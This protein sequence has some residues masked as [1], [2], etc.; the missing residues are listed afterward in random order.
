MNILIGLLIL[1]VLAIVLYFQ[2]KEVE[3]KHKSKKILDDLKTFSYFVSNCTINKKNKEIVAAKI[4]EF[5]K[6]TGYMASR[7]F[8]DL[9]LNVYK[10]YIKR[11]I[12]MGTV[13]KTETTL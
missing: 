10:V 3:Y 12:Y 13:P 4:K 1:L 2:Q 9:L 6:Q 11:F 7:E 5:Q 8:D